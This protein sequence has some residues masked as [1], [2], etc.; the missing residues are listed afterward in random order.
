VCVAIDRLSAIKQLLGKA[1]SDRLV[2]HVA[3]TVGSLIR[4]SDIVAR[5][6]DD[7]V[8]AVLPRAPRGGAMHVAEKICRAVQAKCPPDCQTP[9]VT[10]SIGVA[11]FPSCADNVYSL[12]DAADEALAWAQKN[13]RSQA[14][15]AHPRPM[16]AARQ[17]IGVPSAV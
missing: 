9:S 16:E 2:Q 14:V 11:A 5:L 8:V 4:A 10:V 15:L 6:D 3:D 13:G 12:F 7:R 17:A 1:E